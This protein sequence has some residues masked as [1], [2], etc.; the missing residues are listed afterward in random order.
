MNVLVLGA[1][2]FIGGHIAKAALL[3]GWHTR[4]LRRD[5]TST[6]HVGNLDIQWFKG[7]LDEPQSVK[8]ALNKVD[9]VFHAAG[10]YPTRKDRRSLADK[11]LHAREQIETLV[12]IAA[13][14]NISR[15]IYTSSLSTIGFPQPGSNRLANEN[16]FY[17]PGDVKGSAYYETKYVMESILLD[18]ASRRFPAVILNPTAVFGPGDVHLTSGRLLLAAARGRLIAWLPGIVNVV[19][20]R[21]VASAHIQAVHHGIVGERYIL[22]GQNLSIH[23]A[24]LQV[25]KTLG[26]KPPRFEIPNWLLDMVIKLDNMIPYA[27]LSG[28]HL[29]AMLRWR[30]FDSSKA[31]KK[32]GLTT[33]P[34]SESI[35]DALDWFIEYGYLPELAR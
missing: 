23:E 8:R 29:Q 1:T 9:V 5:D 3:A 18:A 2:G 32:L 27:N 19:D 35:Q 24:M 6:G 34:F 33:R 22:G 11:L 12:D 10:Y 30:G 25:S 28:N 26:I 15:F 20:V 14:A 4:G 17:K 13:Q 16:D 21:D 31:V 7:E